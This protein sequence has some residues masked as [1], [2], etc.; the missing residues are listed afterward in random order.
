MCNLLCFEVN[1]DK[2]L[3]NKNFQTCII[4]IQNNY[5]AA[6]RLLGSLTQETL[7]FRYGSV[8]QTTS[9]SSADRLKVDRTAE[10]NGIHIFGN[11]S[12]QGRPI[13]ILQLFCGKV[14]QSGVDQCFK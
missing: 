3:L 14:D 5:I 13:Q 6:A 11:D 1:F 7:V 2:I 4:F 8:V 9:E 12:D 10:S